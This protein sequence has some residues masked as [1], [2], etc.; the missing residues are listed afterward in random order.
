[1]KQI[2]FVCQGNICRSPSAEAVFNAKIKKAG[3]HKKYSCD[4]AGTIAYHVG[5]AADAR[6]QRHANKRGYKLTSISRK[7][8]EHTDFDSFDMIIAMDDSNL[9]DLERLARGKNVDDKICKMTDFCS[10]YEYESVP[11]PYYGGDAGFELVLDL[12]ENACD[13]LINHLEHEG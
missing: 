11:D 4:S 5:E 8:N 9:I 12:L 3:L 6:M 2:L 10:P 13:G 1:M 7:I